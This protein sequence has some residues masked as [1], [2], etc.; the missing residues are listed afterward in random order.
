MVIIASILIVVSIGMVEKKHFIHLIENEKLAFFLSIFVAIIVVA[1]DPI[2]GIAV[3]TIIALL[4]FVN[5]LSYGQTEV[6]LWKN[7]KMT[8]A[9]LKNDFL[10]KKIIHS[11]IVVYKISGTLTYINASSFGGRKKNKE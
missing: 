4:I 7:G 3:G 10:K 8:E 5:K 2:M 6:L 11:D 9:I 1:E